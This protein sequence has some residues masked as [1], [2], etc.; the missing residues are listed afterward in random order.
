MTWKAF[1]SVEARRL[2]LDGRS[3]RERG[4]D[5]DG[6]RPD[7]PGTGRRSKVPNPLVS[8]LTKLTPAGS[9]SWATTPVASPVPV[10][11]RVMV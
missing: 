1:T 9:A 4:R 6:D 10:L 2:G 11:A 3:D 5:A 8:A 7:V